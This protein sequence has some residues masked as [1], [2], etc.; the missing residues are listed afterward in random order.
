MKKSITFRRMEHSNALANYVDEQLVKLEE[1]LQNEP[2]PIFLDVVLE[3]EPRRSVSKGEI[4]LKTPHYNLISNYQAP[5]MYDVI[6]HIVDV[7]Y[8]KVHEKK[9]ELLDERKKADAY[10]GA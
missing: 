3:A 10:K 2:T 9:K 4:R 5:D 6:D 8:N 1:F 7:I